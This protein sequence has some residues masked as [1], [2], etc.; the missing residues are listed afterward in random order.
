MRRKRSARRPAGGV[1]E[2]GGDQILVRLAGVG[3]ARRAS[4]VRGGVR[5][6]Y[7]EARAGRLSYGVLEPLDFRSLCK[8]RGTEDTNYF[9]YV[10][11]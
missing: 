10:L 11:F 2:R 3:E 9:R 5:H 1:V 7:G 6:G 8:E 4:L